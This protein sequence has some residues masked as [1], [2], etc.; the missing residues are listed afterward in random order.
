MR[1]KLPILGAIVGV[2]AVLGGT[3]WSQQDKPDRGRFTLIAPDTDQTHLD[4]GTPGPSQGDLFIF[5][6]PLNDEKG[7]A[8]GRL[9]G[10]CITVSTP[11]KNDPERDRR[12]CFATSTIGTENGETEIQAQGVGRI[13]AEDVSFSVTGGTMQYTRARGQVLFDYSTNDQVTLSYVL[14]LD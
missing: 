3:A 11:D 7:A 9:D 8:Q 6:G 2:L 1:Q 10:H 13:L 12:Q 14:I 5:S 4:L